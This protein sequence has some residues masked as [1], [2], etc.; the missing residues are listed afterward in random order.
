MV[1]A[2]VNADGFHARNP[3]CGG[4]P[5]IGT[6]IQVA[7][8]VNAP[9][10][11][12]AMGY[13]VGWGIVVHIQPGVFFSGASS[14]SDYVTPALLALVSLYNPVGLGTPPLRL[15]ELCSQ[16][17]DSDPTHGSQP[18]LGLYVALLP[19]VHLSRSLPP[20]RTVL[21]V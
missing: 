18:L 20:H 4:H 12:V 9:P 3:C 11:H 14:Q 19:Q 15:S 10:S 16:E 7:W 2:L 5:R 21:P 1:R 13:V 17:G 8:F 6:F